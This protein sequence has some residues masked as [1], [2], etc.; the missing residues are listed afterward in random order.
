MNVK[1]EIPTGS[2]TWI[3]G[4][5]SPIPRWWTTLSTLRLNH[6]AYL[7]QPSKPNSAATVAINQ[8]RRADATR[9]RWTRRPPA[10]VQTVEIAR[11]NTKRQS[12]HP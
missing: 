6:P 4:T 7:N 10:T 8:A 5:G 9:A 2:V 3:N 1:N 12:H 11:R